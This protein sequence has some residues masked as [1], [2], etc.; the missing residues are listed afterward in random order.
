MQ[1][2]EHDE[3]GVGAVLIFVFVAIAGLVV[4]GMISLNT[5]TSQNRQ[6]IGE[7]FNREARLLADSGLNQGAA[8]LKLDDSDGFNDS[9]LTSDNPIESVTIN[10]TVYSMHQWIDTFTMKTGRYYKVWIADNDDAGYTYGDASNDTITD[11]DTDE[12]RAVIL[13][14]KG[15][16]VEEDGNKIVTVYLK[17]IYKMV[18]QKAA[19]AVVTD[20][21][22]S[23]NGS[24]SISGS[25][26]C[27][28]TNGDLT[29][30]GGSASCEGVAT[31]SGSVTGTFDDTLNGGTTGVPN[32]PIEAVH[33]FSA[34]YYRS[35][36]TDLGSSLVY[37]TSV[38]TIAD[39][40]C[41]RA[42]D[43][44]TDCVEICNDTG[45]YTVYSPKSGSEICTEEG[46]NTNSSGVFY[47]DGPVEVDV[48]EVWAAAV[49]ATGTITISTNDTITG[50]FDL[51]GVG[52]VS[53]ADIVFSGSASIG[54]PENQMGIYAAGD[55][56]FQGG[57]GRII[58]GALIAS[59]GGS[60]SV[61]GSVTF[62]YDNNFPPMNGPADG[63]LV[64]WTYMN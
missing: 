35:L 40:D 3:R 1:K 56:D 37:D 51:P 17:A 20:G 18:S 4:F 50:T 34:D 59:G 13:V 33:F 12:D 58:Y 43:A 23:F 2:R 29:I 21:N 49:L 61:G 26:P 48:S 15:W 6:V 62:I 36:T 28:H 52:F 32:S 46:G 47:F 24:V 31:A 11:D 57:G 8:K 7:K 22:L 9:E 54:V 38:D 42:P 53:D 39:G 41:V 16:V 25:D 30:T 27:L 64:S 19:H 14:S 45:A 10:G 63:Q 44:G 60:S 5:S 55:I